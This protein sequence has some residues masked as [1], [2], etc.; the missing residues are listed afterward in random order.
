MTTLPADVL[1]CLVGHIT[2][3]PDLS[4]LCRCNRALNEIVIPC[5]YNSLKFSVHYPGTIARVLKSNDFFQKHCRRLSVTIDGS[6]DIGDESAY[7]EK[8]TEELEEYW[9]LE[10]RAEILSCLRYVIKHCS[11]RGLLHFSWDIGDID[12]STS[13]L[14]DA[15]QYALKLSR[16]SLSSVDINLTASRYFSCK[17]NIVSESMYKSNFHPIDHS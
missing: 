5:L 7:E 13:W 4:N 17:Q 9:A 6:P 3:Q 14:L 15:M 2:S 11:T 16:R 10:S 8:E 12:L 1:H